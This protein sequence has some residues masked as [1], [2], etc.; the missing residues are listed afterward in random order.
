MSRTLPQSALLIAAVV[1][2]GLVTAGAVVATDGPVTAVDGTASDIATVPNTTNYA[3]PAAS[4]PSRQGYVRSNL[5]VAAAVATDVERLQ[6]Q[7][8]RLAFEQRYAAK[9]T[10]EERLDVVRATITRTEARIETLDSRQETLFRA[11]TSDSISAETFLR[12]LA[13][14]DASAAESRAL[15]ER[16]GNRVRSDIDTSLPVS[17][18]TKLAALRGELVTIPGPLSAEVS[19]TLRGEASPVTV[20][21]QGAGNGIV[22]ATV[23]ESEFL[24]QATLRS[25]YTPGVPNQ[26]AQTEEEPI[27]VA[28]DRARQLYP[29]VSNNLQSINRIAGFGDSDVYLIALSHPHGDLRSYVH[30]GSTDVFREEHSQRPDAIPVQLTASNV[31]NTLELRVNAT[32][33]T[34]PMRLT[35]SR[36][37]TNVPTE[38]TIR[39]N[40]DRVGSTGGDG[41]LW[42]IR[43]SGSLRVNATTDDGTSVVVTRP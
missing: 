1:L 29:W 26:F 13:R 21:T 5:D 30:G 28:F 4:S 40:G 42:T 12:R 18:Q 14:L 23:D 17:T 32:A 24:R 2:L 38:A 39:V 41:A 43:P 8:K 6:G 7:R 15:L 22:L 16:V 10:S 37:T 27:S 36:G 19:G 9:N 11:Y 33:E 20:Y 3:F 25:E 35:V 34:G 31:N